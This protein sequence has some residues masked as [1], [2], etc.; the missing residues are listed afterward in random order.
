MELSNPVHPTFQTTR[1][2]KG[3]SKRKYP[4]VPII[5]VTEKKRT[6]QIQLT[7]SNPHH[8]WLYFTLIFIS[9][10]LSVRP[11]RCQSSKIPP[12]NAV[13][14]PCSRFDFS[15]LITP[16]IESV[17]LHTHCTTTAYAEK[18]TKMQNIN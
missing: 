9:F 1:F 6:T 10:Y 2:Q 5:K 3:G 13:G 8:L 7:I 11:L 17:S 16:F 12:T 4:V 14:D 15:R 18:P